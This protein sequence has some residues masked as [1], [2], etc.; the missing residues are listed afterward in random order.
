MLGFYCRF[1]LFAFS[2]SKQFCAFCS[3]EFRIQT[4]VSCSW[5]ALSQVNGMSQFIKNIFDIETLGYI[6]KC[7]FGKFARCQVETC[8]RG[9]EAE[10]CLLAG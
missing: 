1:I 2:E 6:A 10:N 8:G 7:P 9:G 3:M 5:R 4:V